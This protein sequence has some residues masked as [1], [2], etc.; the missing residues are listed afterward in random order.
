V[1]A[2]RIDRLR[3]H[4]PEWKADA[5]VLTNPANRM[6][7]TGFSSYLGMPWSADCAI[8]G[9]DSVDLLV[10]AIHSGWA[11]GESV[12]A[13][14]VVS[15]KGAYATSLAAFL[16]ERGF[17]NVAIEADSLPY[18][19]GNKLEEAF[20]GQIEFVTGL[21]DELRTV[22]DESEL[23]LLR[24]AAQITDAVFEEIAAGTLVGRT[25]ADLARSI[26]ARLIENGD[27]LA[28]DVIVASGSNAARPHH[29][30]SA[31]T[32]QEREPIVI[33]MGA[34]VGGYCGDLTRTLWVGDH[35]ERFVAVYRAVLA[36]QDATK[37]AMIDGTPVRDVGR[38]ADQS[39]QDSGYGEYILHS[40]GHGVGLDI[41]EGPSIRPELDAVLKSGSVVTVEPG[42][43]I[44]DWGGIRI[45]DVVIVGN[46]TCETITEASKLMTLQG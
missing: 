18:P 4:L 26:S 45:E 38:A 9:P 35:D 17:R 19:E 33:D 40:V 20:S 25:E 41:H 1:T 12:V 29:R 27:G 24:E 23:A 39:L 2:A 22:K 28:F 11:R 8:I 13:T 42:V 43:Y 14:D 30:P 31:R 46:E 5:L 7:S 10:A 15:H 16:E 34:R 21:R 44:P 32:I 6:Y 37:A 3:V 36:A